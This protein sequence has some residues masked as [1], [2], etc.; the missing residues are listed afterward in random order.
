[1][2]C[3]D[4][5][6]TTLFLGN[7]LYIQIEFSVQKKLPENFYQSLLEAINELL[8]TSQVL[9]SSSVDVHLGI[10]I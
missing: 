10:H 3:S 9:I 5:K 4:Q 2:V 8:I 7:Y 1:M 6:T